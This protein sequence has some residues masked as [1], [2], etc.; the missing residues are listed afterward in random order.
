MT[1]HKKILPFR[2]I[3]FSQKTI[4]SLSDVVTPPYDVISPEMQR[5]FYARSPHNFCR[6]DLTQE[7]APQRY[8][9]ARQTYLEWLDKNIIIEDGKPAIYLHHHSFV[10]PD[11]R[12][13]TRQGFLALRRIEDFSEGGIRPHEKTLAAPKL[14]RLELTRALKAQLS[15]VFALYND[16]N[17][18]I[19][20]AVSRTSQST[21]FV[22][23]VSAD[24]ERHQMWKI[25][26]PNICALIDS[27][28]S[29]T[30]LFIADGHHR[31]ETA[32]NYR[33]ELLA[34]HP[35]LPENAAARFV[36]MYFSNMRD[37]GLVILPIH[38][39][40][41]NISGFSLQHFLATLS[42]DFK[43]T[44]HATQDENEMELLLK[45]SGEH[46]HSFFMITKDRKN[47]YLVSMSKEKWQTHPAAQNI[48]PELKQLDVTVL[49]RH[50]LEKILGM[51]EED[52][53]QQ[54][55]LVYWK[56]LQKAVGE[57]WNGPCD[58]SLLMNPTRIEQMEAVAL[59]GQKM[60]QKSTYFYPKIVSG[61]VW[62]DVSE[63]C[64]DGLG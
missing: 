19:I 64:I 26:D 54:K 41:H 8:N 1:I 25:Q 31:Y 17:S 34:Q 15:P 33:N 14:D 3:H 51:S 60:P 30:P 9:V 13:V 58:V 56:S 18:Q 62:H 45:K 12:K 44:A 11:G 53:A 24:E 55:N 35:D 59:S 10:L 20:K 36:F 2:A 32:L 49:H 46:N 27:T 63:N 16:R 38:R 47:S 50:I 5:E 37:P 52:Q 40:L 48:T 7:A 28:L 22:D 57:T 6:V 61:L 42:G 43:I 39:A 29:A 23:F 4:S 21:A